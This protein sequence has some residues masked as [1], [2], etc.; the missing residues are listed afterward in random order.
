MTGIFSKMM[1]VSNAFY[2]ANKIAVYAN[3]EFANNANLGFI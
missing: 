2:S 1:A 3:T